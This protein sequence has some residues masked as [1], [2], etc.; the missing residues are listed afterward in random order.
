MPAV[1]VSPTRRRRRAR[2]PRRFLW[3]T[4]RERAAVQA[5]REAILK[6]PS[7]KLA[8]IDVDF[9]SRKEN[10]PLRMQLELLKT[11]TLL[12]EQRHRLDGRGIRRHADRAARAGRGC[13]ARGEAQRGKIAER[14]EAAAHGAAGRANPG[15]SRITT[16]KPANSAGWFP[17]RRK[18]T[19]RES[20]W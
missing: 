5:N 16:T 14:S 18:R 13:A 19:I 20:S 8:E 4:K 11:E 9:I 1:D 17:R 10:R 12:H 2:Q 15:Q 3:R 6:S 7:Y